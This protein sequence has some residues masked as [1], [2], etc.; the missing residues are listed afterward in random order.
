MRFPS[1]RTGRTATRRRGSP[2]R[3]RH[4]LRRS[5]R[6]LRLESLEARLFLS[7]EGVLSPISPGWFADFSDAAAPRHVNPAGLTLDELSDSSDK[8]GV[9]DADGLDAFDWIVQFDTASLAGISSA[10][11]TAD[12][13]DSAAGSEGRWAAGNVQF[14]VLRGLGLAGQVVVRSSGASTGAVADWLAANVHVASYELDVTRQLQVVPDDTYAWALWGMD[15]TGQTGG[16]ADADIDA[17]EAWEI[18]TGSSSIVVGVID[19]GVDYNHPDLAANI[20]TNPGEIAGNSIDDDGNGFIDDVHGYDFHNNDADPMDDNSHGTHCAG[21][22]AGVGNNGTGVVGVNWSS[23][24]M[25][26]KFLSAEGSGYT[27]NAVRAV[28]YATMMRTTYDVNVRVTSNSWGGGGYSSAM[29]SAIAASGNAGILFAA[30]AGNDATNNDVSP[31][32]P[33]NYAQPSVL[34]VAATDSND[35]MAWFSNYGPNTVHLGAPGQSI[36]STVP[37]GGYSSKSGT[38]MATPHVAGVAALAWSVAPDATVAEIRDAIL[39]GTDPLAA[40]AGKTTSGGRL[41]ALGTLQL[42]NPSNPLAPQIASLTVSPNPI[43]AG[44]SVALTAAGVSDPDGT[45]T[46]VTFYSDTNYDGQWDAGDAVVDTD[47]TIVDSQAS[48]TL[49]TSSRAPG[50]YRFFARAVDDQSNWSIARATILMVNAPDDHGNDA[51]SATAIAAGATLG[52]TIDP[53]SDA[54]WFALSVTA[55][56][57]YRFATE[58]LTLG[59]TELTLYDQDGVTELDWDDDGGPGYAS[60]L[61]FVAPAT[62]TYYVAVTSFAGMGTGTYRLACSVLP[63]DHG[64]IAASASPISVRESAAGSIEFYNDVDYFTFQAPV[65]R[66]YVASTSLSTLEDSVLYVYDQDGTTLLDEDDDGGVGYASQAT[67]TGV[68]G[69]TYYVAVEGYSSYDVGSYTVYVDVPD[70]APILTAVGNRTMSHNLDTMNVTLGATD[71]D[72]DTL[73][74][75]A[76]AVT[77]DPLAQLAYA[78]DQQ[79]GLRYPGGDYYTNARGAGEKYMLG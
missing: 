57:A 12:L 26:L 29:N 74:Y 68:A 66:Q 40:L 52:G 5:S 7:A 14:D 34:S 65:S 43:Y 56:T 18:S 4:K 78:L 6:H 35:A 54:D 45:I 73:T 28:N 16:T 75:T 63:D 69:R 25:A 42:L 13:L 17:A 21:T 77:T 48:I 58:L 20:W 50:G 30:A 3:K 53:A 33:S 72:G 15:N 11:Q 47:A 23:S 31:H 36:Y 51:G 71:A 55:G 44:T 32:Y 61:D 37:G 62:G 2:G 22:I 39:Q 46:G 1:P 41:N 59:D 49:D 60:Q 67:W 19:S 79:L 27:S 76:E 64:S 10:D 8:A 9:V 70:V 24:I 38:S